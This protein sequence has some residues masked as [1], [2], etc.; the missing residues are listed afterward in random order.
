MSQEERDKEAEAVRSLER[1][2]QER[3]INVRSEKQAVEE[4]TVD[5]IEE[6]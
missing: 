5:T 4:H 6:V 1:K 3:K 2:R